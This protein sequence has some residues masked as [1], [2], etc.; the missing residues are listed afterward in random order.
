MEAGDDISLM[1]GEDQGRESREENKKSVKLLDTK[2][3]CRVGMMVESK[4]SWKNGEQLVLVGREALHYVGHVSR[5]GRA[6]NSKM[7]SQF[8][9]FNFQPIKHNGRDQLGVFN[10]YSIFIL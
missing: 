1:L 5:R 2:A 7:F 8:R 10:K 3:G 6:N 9:K 4:A